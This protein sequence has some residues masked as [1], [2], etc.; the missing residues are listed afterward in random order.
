MFFFAQNMDIFEKQHSAA[1]IRGLFW[2]IFL[3][4]GRHCNKSLKGTWMTHVVGSYELSRTQHE[5]SSRANC[6]RKSGKWWPRCD[7]LY[8]LVCFCSLIV[9]ENATFLIDH[10]WTLSYYLLM[11][12]DGVCNKSYL[13]IVN[14]RASNGLMTLNVAYIYRWKNSAFMLLGTCLF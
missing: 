1:W 14:K 6:F 8:S 3:H 4:C 13:V 12:A 2:P 11:G 9:L 7:I 10:D 5:W